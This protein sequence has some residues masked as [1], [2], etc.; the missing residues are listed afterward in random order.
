MEGLDRVLAALSLK[1]ENILPLEIS[2][3]A[4]SSDDI[5]ESIPVVSHSALLEMQVVPA[6]SIFETLR[7]PASQLYAHQPRT[8]QQ[9]VGWQRF[10]AVRIDVDQ[11]APMEPILTPGC[12]VV[13]DRHYNS[14]APYRSQQPSLYAVRSGHLIFRYVSFEENRLIL[15]PYQLRYP[16]LLQQVAPG[17]SPS[18]Q[19][20]GR[21]CMVL[22]EV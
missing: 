12:V 17:D 13:V 5:T 15:R 22:N 14:L 10:L 9:R 1:I 19:I 7:V 11:A 6:S 3:T 21:V 18:S 16:V 20:L 2:A 8:T 4:E